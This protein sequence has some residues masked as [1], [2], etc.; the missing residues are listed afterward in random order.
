MHPREI[1]NTQQSV[2]ASKNCRKSES[3]GNSN[4]KCKTGKRKKMTPSKYW[5]NLTP[6]RKGQVVRGPKINNDKLNQ[7]SMG[8]KRGRW[9]SQTTVEILELVQ[10]YYLNDRALTIPHQKDLSDEAFMVPSSS[11]KIEKCLHPPTLTLLIKKRLAL[12]DKN[13]LTAN[14]G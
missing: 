3:A 9:L 13:T 12:S 6:D 14:K 8:G 2:Q 10:T 5:L 4:E 7:T 11:T 1:Q